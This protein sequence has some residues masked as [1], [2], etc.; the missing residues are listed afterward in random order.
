MD[1]EAVRKALGYDKITLYGYSYGTEL[2]QLYIKY[3]EKSVHK[4]ILAGALGPDH[5]LKLPNDVQAQY[6]K[7]DALIKQD[8]KLSTYIPGFL[9][10]IQ[11]THN[12]IK[13][14][15]VDVKIPD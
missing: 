3:F 6:Q 2:A 5:G 14:N 13:N 8:K 4:A 1:I 9:D 15:P 7:M 11:N 10:L 12:S